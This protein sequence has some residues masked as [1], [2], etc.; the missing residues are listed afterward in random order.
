VPSISPDLWSVALSFDKGPFTLRYAFERHND[1][2]GMAQIGGSAAV[3][4]TNTSSKDIG[5]KIVAAYTLGSTRVAG[6]VERLEYKT[7]DAAISAINAYKKNTFYVLVEQKIGGN[8]I[9]G[10]YGKAKDGSCSRVGGAACNTSNLGASEWSIGY[11]QR[12]SK[13]SELFAV[14]YGI[15]NEASGTYGTQ[16][17]V[18][19]AAIAPGADTRGLGVGM[20]HYF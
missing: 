19:A 3:T 11:I 1:Y 20:I 14:F 4:A 9:W 15:N 10:T 6:A 7:D 2:F 13:R 8:S 16:P 12:L 5:H 17:T 18:G